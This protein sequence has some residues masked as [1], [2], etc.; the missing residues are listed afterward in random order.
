V[1]IF[2]SETERTIPFDLDPPHTITIRKL[3]G[4]EDERAKAA[5]ISVKVRTLVKKFEALRGMLNTAIVEDLK[6]DVADPLVAYDRASVITG[7]LVA[8]T[9]HDG[10]PPT[11]EQIADLDDDAM[12]WIARAILRL[13]KPAAFV[14]AE[15]A[16]KETVAPAPRLR[17]SG[18]TAA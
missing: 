17:G 11:P 7:G 9:Y 13:S 5:G 14:G 4:G 8:W 12:D 16:Q 18:A 15:A 3:R 10:A 2:A 1:S 6:A